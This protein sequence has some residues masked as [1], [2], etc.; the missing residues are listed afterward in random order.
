MNSLP[1]TTT[2]AL[3]STATWDVIVIGA[4]PAG[5]F[6]AAG[7][8]RA[9]V[10]TLLV[11]R[12]AFPRHKVCGGCLNGRAVG[13]LER[14][15]LAAEL[16]ARGARPLSA[17]Q[18]R[19]G[20]HRADLDLP[21]GMAVTRATLDAVLVQSAIAAGCAFLPETSAL[22][23]AENAARNARRDGMRRVTLQPRDAESVMVCARL[24]VVADGLGHGSLRDSPSVQ[25]VVQPDARVGVGAIADTGCVATLRGCV[26]MVVGREG[27]VG[28][29]AVEDDR[30]NIAAALDTD[31]LKAR[32]GPAKAVRAILSS[33]GVTASSALDTLDWLGT[34]PLTRRVLRPVAQRLFV[35]GDAAGYIEPFTGEGMAWALSAADALVPLAARAVSTWDAS[36]ERQW[37]ATYDEVVRRN[38]RRCRI[39]ARTLRYPMLVGAM[40][41][42]LSRQPVLARPFLGDPR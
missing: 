4:G 32:G 3:A 36:I 19:H 34:V 8:A 33:G 31:F 23:E 15:G 28:V 21:S 12:K 7:L 29:T 42:A 41:T 20:R 37:I 11:D 39:I 22:V 14:A 30:I 9:G 24:V 17:I 25:G 40:V 1:G 16:R 13:L 10:A 38:Q 18:L 2:A 26:T 6:A 27:Y 35:I 5:A